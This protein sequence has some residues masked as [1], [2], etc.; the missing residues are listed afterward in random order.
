MFTSRHNRTGY[1]VIDDEV[2]DDAPPTTFEGFPTHRSDAHSQS[3]AEPLVNERALGATDMFGG[4]PLSHNISG[5]N[6]E[7]IDLAKSSLSYD[8][9]WDHVENLD[10]DAIVSGCITRL[11]PLV[12]AALLFAILFWIFR[13]IRDG[14]HLVQFYEIHNF[15]EEALASE[16]EGT[17]FYMGIANLVFFPLI[18]LYQILYS[19]F[20][21]AE[22]VKREPGALGMRRYSNYGRSKIRHFNELDHEL[23]M[24]L[25]RSHRAAQ[26]YM[27]Q[28]ISPLKEIIAKNV[29]FVAGALFATLAL[30]SAWDEDVLA[31]YFVSFV[32]KELLPP[33]LHVPFMGPIPYLSNGLK[34]NLEWLLFWGPWSPWE[35]PYAL[36]DD[37]KHQHNIARLTSEMEGTIFYMG[38]ANL[39]FFPLI[40]L[41]QIL[42]SFF[43]YAELV[44]REPGA[45]GM[46]RY[47]NYG[48]SKIRHFNE[49]DHELRMRLSRSHRAAQQYMDQFIS[50]LKEIIAKNVAFVAGALFATLALLSAWDEDVLAV[51]HVLTAMTVCGVLIVVCRSFIADENLIWWPE[52]LMNRII[53]QIHYA[54]DTWKDRA[55]TVAV[56]Q[57]FGHLFQLKAQFIVEELLSPLVTPFVLLFWIRPKARE[58]VNFFYNFTVSVDGLGDVCSFAQ[59]DVSRHGDPAWNGDFQ[60]AGQSETA[61]PVASEGEKVSAND[62]KTELSLLHFMATNP[63]WKPPAGSVRFVNEFRNRMEREL[64]NLRE[65][66]LEG[67]ILLESIHAAFPLQYPTALAT[68][69]THRVCGEG[70]ARLDGPAQLTSD[71]LI[72]SLHQSGLLNQQSS[73]YTPGVSDDAV[74][75]TAAAEMS[76][77]TMC[78]RRMHAQHDASQNAFNYGTIGSATTVTDREGGLTAAGSS[79]GQSISDIWGVPAQSTVVPRQRTHP[80]Q[81]QSHMAHITE[82][83]DESEDRP[84]DFFQ[85]V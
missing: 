14:Y 54:P 5:D 15:Y 6:A 63:D 2:E 36:K 10:Q 26:Q 61:V 31:N 78:L 25:S 82:T 11:H 62:G 29:A 50:P 53:A 43:S 41:Y 58:F 22:L 47:S 30:L 75:D 56:R 66:S 13:V 39:V 79:A 85:S 65:S 35:G 33:V 46:R 20:S 83:T 69:R 45:L 71:S 49:L 52:F 34:L 9:R 48:R 37:Y 44:K 51:E 77:T 59:M 24:R 16:M 12:A 76:L 74:T 42:Y 67:N 73:F 32:N 72:A 60:L 40:L 21:Y 28:F 38:I 8:G 64:T 7:A 81:E 84:P 18:L 27:D 19:F 23:R 4:P 1:Q 3:E 80:V 57:E 55:H 17:I 68:Q 70:A